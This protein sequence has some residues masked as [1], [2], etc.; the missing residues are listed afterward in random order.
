[1]IDSDP[2]QQ[3]GPPVGAA[4]EHIAGLTRRRLL[5]VGAKGALAVGG[6]SLLAACGAG[7]SQSRSVS[8]SPTS[9][10]PKLPTSS[11]GGT[12]VHG[13]TLIVGGIT[14]GTSETINPILA[15]S[16]IDVLS[17]LQVFDRL[18]KASA[19]Q[20]S[21]L[22]Q[23]A[24]SA[25]PSKDFTVWTLK[26]R[27]N[28]TW[29]DGTP[30]S[31]DDVVYSMQSFWANP[32]GYGAWAT[33]NI[34]L[35]NIRKRGN[36]TVEVP[37]HSPDTEFPFLSVPYTS[38]IV[39]SGTKPSSFTKGLP[40]GTGPFK[41]VSFHRG[42]QRTFAR[43]ANYWESGKPYLDK[44][45]FDTSFA[46][47]TTRLNALLGGQIKLMP[48]AA[49]LSAKAQLGSS[50]VTLFGSPSPQPNAIVMRVDK[51]QYADPRVRQAMKLVANRQGLIDGALAG[52]ATPGADLLGASS[53]YYDASAKA[54]YDPEKAK[55]LIKAAGM[56]NDTFVMQTA[57]V[58]PGQVSAATLFAE[59]ASAAGIKLTLQQE[60]QGVYFTGPGGYLSAHLRQDTYL[61]Y[62]SLDASYRSLLTDPGK[63]LLNESYWGAQ[64]PGG[65]GAQ[66]DLAAA[67]AATTASKATSAW[68]K[69]QQQQVESGG[70]LIWANSYFLHLAD[71]TVKNFVESPAGF[72][73]DNRMLDGWVTT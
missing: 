1:M 49:P 52:F 19:D 9:A 24:V 23:L 10:I 31:A 16:F 6:A 44:L 67:L 21:V 32:G 72:L 43:N 34:D 62:A 17:L 40:V 41:V 60:Q 8:S 39:K 2:A 38:A 66:A 11:G 5:G 14:G 58:A 51:G 68:L 4:V 15:S 70:L 33:T 63:N 57:A 7:G 27:P 29:H 50:S 42:Q 46:D 69:V 3:H 13:G 53:M 73:D 18:F 25:E 28:V 22:P 61:P 56:S 45:I 30:F 20:R 59:Q 48:F 64:N 71:P 35:K 65:A 37:L 54:A 55:S 12:P 26:L 36:L 47:E